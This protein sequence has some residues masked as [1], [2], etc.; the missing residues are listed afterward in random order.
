MDDTEH[1][2]NRFLVQ[3]F[4]ELLRAE[5]RCLSTGSFDDL[6]LKELHVIEV[7]ALCAGEE[8]LPPQPE[9]M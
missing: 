9:P 8:E 5:E 3:A 2:L 7:A 6:S 1:T 4:H